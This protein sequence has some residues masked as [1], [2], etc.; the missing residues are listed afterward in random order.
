MKEQLISFKTAILAREKG[1]DI[2]CDWR[3][4]ESENIPTYFNWRDYRVAECT[5]CDRS[6]AYKA[7]EY[8]SENYYDVFNNDDEGFYLSAPTQSLLKKWL[9][10]KHNIQIEIELNTKYIKDILTNLYSYQM[11]KPSE[12]LKLSWKFSGCKYLIYE[13][14]LEKGLYEALKLIK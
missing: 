1:F 3:Y 9:R 5:S 6:Y 2:H 11:Y 14:A 7:V 12:Q 8:L 10:D 4:N 13:E